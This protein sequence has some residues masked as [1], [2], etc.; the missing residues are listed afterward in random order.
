MYTHT[1]QTLPYKHIH[2]HSY[3]GV[4]VHINTQTYTFVNEMKYSY[5]DI[6]TQRLIHI[7][8]YVHL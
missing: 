8:G 3:I 5:T 1:A 4:L 7:T 6:V 2:T